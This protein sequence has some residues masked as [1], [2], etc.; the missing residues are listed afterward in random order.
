MLETF[1]ISTHGRFHPRIVRAVSSER[2][3]ALRLIFSGRN[4]GRSEPAKIRYAHAGAWNNLTLQPRDNR[5]DD[6][7]PRLLRR[8]CSY[9]SYARWNR[10]SEESKEESNVNFANV[11]PIPSSR[12]SFTD[13]WESSWRDCIDCPSPI[14]YPIR[15]NRLYRNRTLPGSPAAAP[16]FIWFSIL[17]ASGTNLSCNFQYFRRPIEHVSATA[18]ISRRPFIALRIFKVWKGLG[19]FPP[20]GTRRK[21]PCIRDRHKCK[22]FSLDAS[23]EI[24]VLSL[25]KISVMLWKRKKIFA[26]SICSRCARDCTFRYL[27]LSLCF[28]LF[29]Y[30]NHFLP[31]SGKRWKEIKLEHRLKIP[32]QLSYFHTATR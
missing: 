26:R 21:A 32:L 11:P 9:A 8:R 25:G 14:N 22:A 18:S 31:E 6:N 13:T 12:R 23:R 2:S 20:K 16:F 28:S 3:S 1:S 27:S 24:Y 10:C 19:L 4:D 17:H 15:A 5:I 7:P 30:Q 29:S